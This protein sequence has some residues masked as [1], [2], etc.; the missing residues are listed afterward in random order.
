[1]NWKEL[2]TA[3]YASLQDEFFFKDYKFDYDIT[4][5]ASGGNTNATFTQFQ[6]KI[7]MRSTNQAVVPLLKDLRCIALA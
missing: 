5:V 2:T 7:R 3:N 6:V 4:D 1:M